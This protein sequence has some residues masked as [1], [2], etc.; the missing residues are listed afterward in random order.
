MQVGD[1]VQW[2]GGDGDEVLI[3]GEITGEQDD[4]WLITEAHAFHRLWGGS[5]GM[6][7]HVHEVPKTREDLRRATYYKHTV[8]QGMA[9]YRKN[10][11]KW[12]NQRADNAR[13][14][15]E[16]EAQNQRDEDLAPTNP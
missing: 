2:C 14:M 6:R 4:V 1:P 16:A 9:T 5:S 12:D 11:Q 10:P 3:V 7:G 15:A 13:R 8:E